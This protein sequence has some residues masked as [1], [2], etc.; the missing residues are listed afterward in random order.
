ML[1]SLEM[2]SQLPFLFLAFLLGCFNPDLAKA[3]LL[4]DGVAHFCPESY[5]CVNGI[6]MNGGVLSD[7]PDLAM[8]GDLAGV[9]L[10]GVD[11]APKPPAVGCKDPNNPLSQDVSNINSDMGWGQAYT[12]PGAF[13]ASSDPT[14]NASSL[15]AAGYHVCDYGETKTK[16]S[17][18]GALCANLRAGY[19]FVDITASWNP[20][21]PPTAITAVACAVAA[22]PDLPGFMTCGWP[23]T[24]RTEHF[25]TGPCKG[26]GGWGL[27]TD[28]PGVT[29]AAPYTS[30]S[31]A[32]STNKNNG[33]VCC[34]NW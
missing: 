12:C 28:T 13:E 33:V 19:Y 30:L 6:C 31:L 23:Y 24:M 4:C 7:A 26:L 3:R 10:A 14:K 21:S 1:P 11:L 5:A 22:P 2:K 25:V 27:F 15:C 17:L 18:N 9:D 8:S 16:Y 32:S 20:A 29:I 34:K